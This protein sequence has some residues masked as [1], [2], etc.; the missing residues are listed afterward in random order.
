MLPI[1]CINCEG[2]RGTWSVLKQH[3]CIWT[4]QLLRTRSSKNAA[5]ILRTSN[6]KTLFDQRYKTQAAATQNLQEVGISPKGVVMRHLSTPAALFLRRSW[7]GQGAGEEVWQ[8]G[9]PSPGPPAPWRSGLRRLLCLGAA[10]ALIFLR[11][12]MRKSRRERERQRD[13]VHSR[14][15]AVPLELRPGWS[16][17]S[18]IACFFFFF[19]FLNFFFPWCFRL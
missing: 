13:R 18:N 4:E 7:R 11:E 19:L 6:T 12:R 3:T 15:A 5:T 1:A 17:D 14:H 16:P 8:V 10:A 2:L 9:C